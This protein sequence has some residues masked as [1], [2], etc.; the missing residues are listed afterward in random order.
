MAAAGLGGA[1]ANLTKFDIVRDFAQ[2]AALFFAGIAS[3]GL[4]LA[5]K[6]SGRVFGLI[7]VDL[8][9]VYEGINPFHIM[10][11]LTVLAILLV[12]AIIVF[13]CMSRRL[14]PD[15]IRQVVFFM[16]E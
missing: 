1:L 3:E 12:I 7:S 6:T 15:E 5:K 13:Y 8:T 14:N 9:M 16:V 10:M 2:N 11:L 4:E